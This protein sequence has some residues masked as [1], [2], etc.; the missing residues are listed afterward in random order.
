MSQVHVC[1][2]GQKPGKFT[3]KELGHFICSGTEP[4]SKPGI[5]DRRQRFNC[6]EESDTGLRLHLQLNC[7]AVT[8]TTDDKT[9]KAWA[10]TASWH[11]TRGAFGF[12]I[13]WTKSLT[14]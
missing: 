10:V 9:N 5:F 13:T 7:W 1:N 3:R 11:Q 8:P 12:K 14:C 6:L 4:I 2:T